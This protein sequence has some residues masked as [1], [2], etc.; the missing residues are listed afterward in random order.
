MRMTIFHKGLLLISL[1]LICEYLFIAAVYRAN[2]QAAEADFWAEHSKQVLLLADDVLSNA[3]E[4]QSAARA[5]VLRS[6]VDYDREFRTARD[7]CMAHADDLY[8]LVSDKSE[9]QRQVAEI[10][11]ALV[12][13]MD[14]LSQQANDAVNGRTESATTRVQSGKGGDLMVG[15]RARMAAFLTREEEFDQRRATDLKDARR[16]L[17]QTLVVSAALSTAITAVAVAIFGGSVARRIGLMTSNASRMAEGSPLNPQ[18]PG[19]DEIAVLDRA[20]HDAAGRLRR[21]A[22]AEASYKR[23]IESRAEELSRV[24]EHL[25]QQTQENEMF[26]YSVSHDLRSPLVNLQG[27]SRELGL[28]A[29]DLQDTLADERVPQD[30]RGKVTAVLEQ[31]MGSSI[32][33]IQTAVSRSS[34]IID[35]LLRLSRAGR[36]EYKSVEVDVALIVRRV[37][38]AMRDTI[39]RKGAQMRVARLEPCLGDTTAVEQIFGNLIGNAVNYLDPSRPGKIEVGMLEAPATSGRRTYFVRDNGLGIPSAYLGKVFVAFQRLHGEVAKGEGIGLALVRRVVERH[40]GAVRVESTV[41]VGTTFYVELPAVAEAVGQ[42][43]PSAGKREA[44]SEI[45][46]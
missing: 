35:A 1:P 45:P 5:A 25:R 4:A 10:R 39:D 30:V 41:G 31:D 20:M 15:F 33:F 26:V 7:R 46:S 11:E 29:K 37:V 43:V 18:L 2:K 24:N 6:R 3:L 13:L 27:F 16:A 22:E 14:W 23:E 32:K 40:G 44:E 28:G 38:D 9:Q 34:A 42:S 19:T 21:S 12:P 36:V 17:T 8:H